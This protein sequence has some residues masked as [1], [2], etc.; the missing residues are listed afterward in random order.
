MSAW[1]I[2]FVGD[3]LITCGDLGRIL[4]YDL[5]SKEMIRKME[6]GDACLSAV[7]KMIN[8]KK[9]AVGNVNGNAY[10]VNV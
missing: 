10:L 9:I 6:A 4:Y 8:E 7:G 2:I 3:S 5:F 1:K